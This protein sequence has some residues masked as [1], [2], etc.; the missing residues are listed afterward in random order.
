[1][2][3]VRSTGME[4]LAED[5]ECWRRQGKV[6][7]QLGAA[8][9]N[10]SGVTYVVCR[11]FLNRWLPGFMLPLERFRCNTILPHTREMLTRGSLMN[12]SLGTSDEGSLSRWLS[13]YMWRGRPCPLLRVET[14]GDRHDRQVLFVLSLL[15]ANRK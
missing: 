11:M 14:L 8:L 10:C 3:R 1:M 4:Y 15:I 13:L 12:V 7:T 2:V 6:R 5:A 9:D